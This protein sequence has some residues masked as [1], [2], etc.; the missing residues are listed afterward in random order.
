MLTVGTSRKASLDLFPFIS[1]F[2]CVIGVLAFL[3]NLLV[4]G[5]IGASEEDTLQ[6][7]I[8]Q[9]AYRIETASDRIVLHPPEV[10]LKEIY[11]KLNLEELASLDR[12]Q[13]NRALDIAS[14]GKTLP[15]AP[16][17]DELSL[18]QALN[19]ISTLNLLAKEHGIEYEEFIL[20]SIHSGGGDTY[21]SLS[22]LLDTPS[23]K[24]I[25]SGLELASNNASVENTQ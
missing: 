11:R 9:T 21:H 16:T 13:A 1:L 14:K 12:V 4:L 17:F 15:F 19:E 7:Q 18:Q 8:F 25:R 2:L 23:L 3:Q 24:H 20:F 22:R 5:D 6:P 10:D